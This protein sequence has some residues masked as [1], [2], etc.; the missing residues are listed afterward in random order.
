[1]SPILKQRFRRDDQTPKPRIK[2]NLKQQNKRVQFSD[3]TQTIDPKKSLDTDTKLESESTKDTDKT[4]VEPGPEQTENNNTLV[5]NESL[6]VR[7]TTNTAITVETN[8]KYAFP[9]PYF[10][11]S[12]L[13]K[14]YFDDSKICFPEY[15]QVCDYALYKKVTTS[16]N[17][18]FH[19][20]NLSSLKTIKEP[21]FSID[22]S[23]Q[24]LIDYLKFQIIV[25]M[26][27]QTL[28]EIT[29]VTTSNV[30]AKF[31]SI[32]QKN[33]DLDSNQQFKTFMSTPQIINK[34]SLDDIKK[35]LSFQL[36]DIEAKTQTNT[37]QLFVVHNEEISKLGIKNL[38]FNMD[39]NIDIIQHCD[40][41]IHGFFRNKFTLDIASQDLKE[42][43]CLPNTVDKPRVTSIVKTIQKLIKESKKT[44]ESSNWDIQQVQLHKFTVPDLLYFL[45]I[46]E[47]FRQGTLLHEYAKLVLRIIIRSINMYSIDI[48]K[49]KDDECYRLGNTYYG[50][51]TD[52][53]KSNYND[54]ICKHQQ[55]PCI[56]DLCINKLNVTMKIVYDIPESV[57]W[58]GLETKSRDRDSVDI[59]LDTK[60]KSRQEKDIDL[61]SNKRQRNIN[62]S[63]S[64]DERQRSDIGISVLERNREKKTL[65]DYSERP[66][67]RQRID[68]NV[69]KSSL[70]TDS[71]PSKL[72]I[73]VKPF[74]YNTTK[75]TQDIQQVST[76]IQ[77]I[78]D[79]VN[80]I[81][82]SK[83]QKIND[84]VDIGKT[85]LN[86][87]NI[88]VKQ[89]PFNVQS[90]DQSVSK[91]NVQLPKYQSIP[92]LVDSKSTVQPVLENNSTQSTKPILSSDVETSEKTLVDN[93][94]TPSIKPTISNLETQT[95]MT[96]PSSTV[97]TVSTQPTPIVKQDLT[98]RKAPKLIDLQG[99]D[100]ESMTSDKSLT[101][102]TTADLH[103]TVK[104]SSQHLDKNMSSQSSEM[105]QSKDSTIELDTSLVTQD[106]T[107]SKNKLNSSAVSVSKISEMT[108][109]SFTYFVPVEHRIK[110]MKEALKQLN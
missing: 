62:A 17:P 64:A 69:D 71:V 99:S 43:P 98:I 67:L 93:D 77:K 76:P 27:S 55:D 32:V 48:S 73:D 13:D 49:L 65:F 20:I 104:P 96:K 103:T 40:F 34:P 80:A 35:I 22:Y 100:D 19:T 3:I 37:S 105:L 81:D 84:N 66:E 91:P 10:I 94:V 42:I 61:T 53:P 33:I 1:M 86:K 60:K 36:F 88:D 78:D 50:K 26:Q 82:L 95:L 54:F 89:M 70:Q 29:G 107:M 106:K 4:L 56:Q 39:Y 6:K 83:T 12:K 7:Q 85:E 79:N 75:L 58:K 102:S 28:E 16:L 18:K 11:D 110:Q 108:R 5:F 31:K 90:I 47:P 23:N 51:F 59:D 8:F 44:P 14:H 9:I 52:I 24:K 25:A 38:A 46:S 21:K 57:I 97:N 30:I 68:I 41:K 45:S 74:E 15:I 72:N 87:I 2:N 101:M 109:L 92:K 63:L